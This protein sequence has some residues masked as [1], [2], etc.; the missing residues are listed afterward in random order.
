[1]IPIPGLEDAI[2][3]LRVEAINKDGVVLRV[4]DNG[5]FILGEG[6]TLTLSELRTSI[7]LTPGSQA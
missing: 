1:M 6:D 2:I 3:V 7:K 5:R 4:A